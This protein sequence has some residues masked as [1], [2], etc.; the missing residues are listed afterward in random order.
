[1]K[2]NEN[3]IPYNGFSFFKI[4][5]DGDMPEDLSKAY[6]DLEEYNDENPRKKYFQIRKKIKNMFKKPK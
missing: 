5:F 3:T 2:P 4:M 6:K 1:M